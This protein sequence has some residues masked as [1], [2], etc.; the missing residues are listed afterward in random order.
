MKEIVALIHSNIFNYITRRLICAKKHEIS[1]YTRRR[2]VKNDWADSGR[3]PGG[4]I[5][6]SGRI[7]AGNPGRQGGFRA[8]SSRIPGGFRADSARNPG[9]SNPAVLF[10]ERGSNITLG[11]S[12]CDRSTATIPR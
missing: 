7:P 5:A 11:Y 12:W 1:H 10:I 6:D 3:N 4:F 9:D 8:D 2:P